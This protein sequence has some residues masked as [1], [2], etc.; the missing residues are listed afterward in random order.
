MTKDTLA[1][2][3]DVYKSTIETF[4]TIYQRTGDKE[5]RARAGGYITA[6][7]DAGIITETEKRTLLCYVTI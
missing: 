3:P 5:T 7:R 2:L 1:K 4:K 6:L